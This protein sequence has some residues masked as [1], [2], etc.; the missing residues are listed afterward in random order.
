MNALSGNTLVTLLNTLTAKNILVVGDLMLDQY[1][2]GNVERISP[3]G[4]IPVLRVN[5]EEFRLG[6]A[7]NVAVNI[8]HLKSSVFP[9][10]LV[11]KD[12]SGDKLLEI[13]EASNISTRGIVRDHSFQTIVKQ[14]AITSQQQLLRID[15]ESAA[16]PEEPLQKSLQKNVEALMPEMH[17]VI[18]SDYAKGV[19]GQELIAT[20]IKLAK[21]KEIPIIC[22]PGKGVDF[23]QYK[24][25]TS[26]K[27][28]RIETEQSTG[29]TLNSQESVLKAAAKL[30]KSCDS[31]FITISLDKDGILYYGGQGDYKFFPSNVP[32]VFD[33]TGAGDT[34]IST[35]SVLLANK[36]S[37]LQSTYVANIAAG[38]ETSHLG[39]VPVPWPE[40]IKHIADD[41]LSRKIT[42]L[43]RLIADLKA[44][45]SNSIIFTNGY[46]DNISAGH[47][48]FLL[49]IGKLSGNLVVAINS[50]NC[51]KRQKG[52]H[53]LLKELDRA[54]L[55]ASME[56]VQH[57]VIF[58]DD[59]ASNLIKELKPDIVV[60]G[61]QFK[62]QNIPETTVIQEI[63]AKIEYIPHFSWEPIT[64]T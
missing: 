20:T 27:P 22:D 38:L 35:L 4:P 17:A 30:K 18:L 52:A 62:D 29:I 56:N 57:V 60:K 36:I 32:E 13:F 45:N 8:N 43:P 59:D 47:L 31:Q 19:L 5:N 33:V 16:N 46:F 54:R 50:D 61:E 44:S 21:R 7:A 25:I 51:I 26:I 23:K 42:T 24:G 14:R 6:G 3:E 63:G 2:W 39:V 55:L 41:S 34:L 10:G 48:R 64:D 9:I 1:I 40:I 11:G 12:Y 15:Y 37:P 53:P 28:N 58:E 49:E